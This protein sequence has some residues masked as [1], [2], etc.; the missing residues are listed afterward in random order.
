[1]GEAAEAGR[2]AMPRPATAALERMA[3]SLG[4]HHFA[5]LRALIQGLAVPEAAARYLHIDH[6]RAARSAYRVVV[7]RARALQALGDG[8]RGSAP[9][10]LSQI[11]RVFTCCEPLHR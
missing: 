9:L 6:A 10:A 1:M 2:G 3:E 8:R 4:L 5:Y 11:S 7:E